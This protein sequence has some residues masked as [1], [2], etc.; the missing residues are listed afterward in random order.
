MNSQSTWAAALAVVLGVVGL[1]YGFPAVPS[2]D[3]ATGIAVGLLVS[4]FAALGLKVSL[5]NGGRR[6]GR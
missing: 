1:L 3:L 4:G 5:W 6:R 2:E